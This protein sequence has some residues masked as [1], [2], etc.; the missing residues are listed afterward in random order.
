MPASYEDL[1]IKTMAQHVKELQRKQKKLS[2]LIA[3]PKELQKIQ[4]EEMEEKQKTMSKKKRRQMMPRHI[5]TPH[6]PKIVS[7]E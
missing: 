6:D 4:Q 3:S 5:A 7:W 1:D 2:R